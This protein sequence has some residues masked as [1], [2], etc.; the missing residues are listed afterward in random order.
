[1]SGSDR[2]LSGIL[3]YK[4]GIFGYLLRLQSNIISNSSTHSFLM[5]KTRILAECI[6]HY[7]MVAS[8]GEFHCFIFKENVM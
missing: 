1:M 2:Q 4:S 8:S 7:R 3:I 6:A 5:P